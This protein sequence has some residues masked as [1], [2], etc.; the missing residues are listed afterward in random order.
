MSVLSFHTF[1]FASFAYLQTKASLMWA[2]KCIC[3]V[4]I[5]CI[6]GLHVIFGQITGVNS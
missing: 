6:L 4:Y 3:L 1:D 2:R 5:E